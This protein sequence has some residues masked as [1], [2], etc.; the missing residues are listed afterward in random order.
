MIRKISIGTDLLKA[1]HFIV[2][3]RVLGDTHTINRIEVSV[4]GYDVWIIN[5]DNEIVKWK[6]INQYV[7]V[8]VEYDLNF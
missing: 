1:M 8:T 3:Q 2:G 4:V 6:H 5:D 7:P